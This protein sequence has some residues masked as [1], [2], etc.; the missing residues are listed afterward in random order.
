MFFC[1]SQQSEH[2]MTN[3]ILTISKC[4]S[5]YTCSH[6]ELT[7]MLTENICRRLHDIS[8]GFTNKK[9]IPKLLSFNWQKKGTSKCQRQSKRYNYFLMKHPLENQMLSMRK[10]SYSAKDGA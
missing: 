5:L 3:N 10:L 7:A 2:V 8:K 9:A 4:L 6:H 1:N